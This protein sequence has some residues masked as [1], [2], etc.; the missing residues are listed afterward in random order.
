M[1][2]NNV[3]RINWPFHPFTFPNGMS[4]EEGFKVLSYLTDFV[5]RDIEPCSLRSIRTLDSVLDLERLAF[6]RVEVENEEEIINLFAVSGRV[7]LFKN[8]ELYSKY[9]EWYTEGVQ[10][11]EVKAIYNI[12]HRALKLFHQKGSGFIIS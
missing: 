3:G 8:S 2:P 12:Y 10:F 1:G 5:E 6:T 11:D 4:R 9:F 7:L